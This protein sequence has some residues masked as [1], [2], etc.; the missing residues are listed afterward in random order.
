MRHAREVAEPPDLARLDAERRGCL[1]NYERRSED[2]GGPQAVGKRLPPGR[3]RLQTP[4]VRD[5]VVGLDREDEIR[6]DPSPPATGHRVGDA[7]IEASVH[8][9]EPKRLGVRPQA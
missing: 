7:T 2:P 8:F 5:I 3:G 4:G 6:R 9:R 1:E